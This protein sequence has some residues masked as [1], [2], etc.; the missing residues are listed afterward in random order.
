MRHRWSGAGFGLALLVLLSG[1]GA[2]VG[3]LTASAPPVPTP[4]PTAEQTRQLGSGGKLMLE[5]ST[6]REYDP[7]T[8]IERT[9]LD[10]QGYNL[11]VYLE[12][13]VFEERTEGYRKINAF[14]QDLKK[15]F[16]SPEE[17]NLTSA[18]EFA[19]S[20][21]S[22]RADQ[23]QYERPA[24]ISTLN[25]RLVSVSIGYE[26]YMSGVYDYGSDSYTFR[27][28]T[29][30]LLC[31]TDLVEE[32]ETQLKEMLREGLRAQDAGNGDLDP[33]LVDQYPLEH[34]EFVVYEDGILIR[35]DKYEASYGAYGGFEI[36]LPATVK[37]E[38]L[39]YHSEDK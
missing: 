26:W 36:A 20:P 23:Y 6:Q 16:F 35:F 2:E 31:L 39:T 3:A 38:W 1:C 32:G 18:W 29:G 15:K 5:Y 37:K 30:E 33:D 7:E 14:F 25:E 24:H 22:T 9:T 8:G 12:V 11:S 19:A 17:E 34:F 28:D 4:A 13:P 21:D 27:T 10:P